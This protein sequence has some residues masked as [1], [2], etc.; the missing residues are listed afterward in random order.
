MDKLAERRKH[1]VILAWK[2]YLQLAKDEKMIE[3]EHNERKAKIDNF[4]LNLK[5]KVETEKSQ[6]AID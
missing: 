2:K 1:K 6:R 3:E 4:F 5:N